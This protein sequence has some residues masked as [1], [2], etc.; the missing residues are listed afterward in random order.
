MNYLNEAIEEIKLALLNSKSD[1]VKEVYLRNAIR[2][3]EA[4]QLK[5]EE[6]EAE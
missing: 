5:L 4:A 2:F 3:I 1:E 6:R